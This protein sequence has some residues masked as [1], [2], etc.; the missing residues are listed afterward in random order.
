MSWV[1]WIGIE[2]EDSENEEVRAVY[3]QARDPRTKAVPDLV[4]LTGRTP[5]VARLLHEL[6]IAVYR[7]ARGFSLRE[8]EIVALLASSYVGCVH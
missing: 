6:S 1:T 5:E 2:G 3:D 4:R 8:K 7:H